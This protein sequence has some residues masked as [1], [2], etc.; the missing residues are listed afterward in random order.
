MLPAVERVLKRRHNLTDK[1]VTALYVAQGISLM[2]AV[3]IVGYFGNFRARK[4][5]CIGAGMALSGKS[6]VKPFE[7]F[8]NL[9]AQAFSIYNIGNR[10][11]A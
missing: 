2:V 9:L 5:R 6:E 3:V 10:P 11:Y 7:K 1:D 8:V 4:I